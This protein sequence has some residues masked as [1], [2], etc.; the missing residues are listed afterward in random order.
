M[1][2]ICSQQHQNRKGKCG[3][4][5][6]AITIIFLG[7][8]N[9]EGMCFLE[10]K[11]CQRSL[12][13]VASELAP[14]MTSFLLSK[15]LHHVTSLKSSFVHLFIPK[16]YLLSTCYM[17][18]ITF[19]MCFCPE[20]SLEVSNAIHKTLIL[21]RP[22][23]GHNLPPPPVPQHQLLQT[24]IPE[25]SGPT[26]LG[27]LAPNVEQI[28]K[29]ISLF[30][31]RAL[32]ETE[33]SQVFLWAKQSLFFAIISKVLHHLEIHTVFLVWKGK[34]FQKLVCDLPRSQGFE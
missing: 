25:S 17:L 4:S 22:Y 8:R 9:L 12:F 30:I 3:S 5:V 27:I 2:R 15:Y 24:R 14:T 32:H 21:T 29:G 11:L 7:D 33:G 19:S 18:R 34:L 28:T 1:Q 23:I 26:V 16:K 13:S 20:L 6:I 10:A 31:K